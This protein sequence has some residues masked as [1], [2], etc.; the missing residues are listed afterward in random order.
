MLNFE[1]SMNN[2]KGHGLVPFCL[3]RFAFGY[4]AIHKTNHLDTNANF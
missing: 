1:T 4:I 2:V 3:Q